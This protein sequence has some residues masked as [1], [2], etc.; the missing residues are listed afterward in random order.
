M[1]RFSLHPCRSTTVQV[2]LLSRQTYD[3]G[4]AAVA[5]GEGAAAGGDAAGAA[6]IAEGAGAGG[7]GAL[8]SD[9]VLIMTA[10]SSLN[11][12]SSSIG[13]ARKG[14]HDR[15]RRNAKD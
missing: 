9:I 1:I 6:A 8:S 11:C 13:S 5:S 7:A 14:D 10:F 12:S 4:S 15:G 2:T 3:V